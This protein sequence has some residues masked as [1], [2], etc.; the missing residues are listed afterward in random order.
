MADTR[1]L[2]G[3]DD[4]LAKLKALPPEIAS[5]RGGPVLKAL[6]RGG[7]VVKKEWQNNIRNVVSNPAA[8]GY[9]S[10]K[11]LEKSVAVVRSKNPQAKGGNEAVTVLISRGKRGTYPEREG[12]KAIATGRYLEFG[13]EKQKAEPWATPGYMS[14]RE[15]ALTAVVDDLSESVNRAIAKVSK[16]G[17]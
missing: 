9:A 13:T 6:R 3:L 2:Q 7:N 11:T 15:K 5:K 8:D 16:G 10:T 12:L 14:S 4:V 1:T 17:L